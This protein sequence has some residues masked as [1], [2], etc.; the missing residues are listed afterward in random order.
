MFNWLKKIHPITLSEKAGNRVNNVL[1]VLM[2]G[3]ITVAVV[4]VIYRIF[5]GTLI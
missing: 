1:I 4:T 5:K 3:L 2:G